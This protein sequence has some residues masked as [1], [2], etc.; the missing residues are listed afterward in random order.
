MNYRKSLQWY[1]RART[2]IPS[3]TQT[4]SKGPTQ[5]PFG[6]S[7][8]YIERGEGSHVWDVDGNEF[9]DYPMGLGA[10]LLGHAYPPVNA[11]IVEQAQK[12]FSFTL[13]SPLEVEVAESLTELIPCAEMVR[14]GKNGSDATAGAIRAARAFTGRDKVVC[15]GY[16]G[17]QDWYIATTT[18]DKGVPRFN[19]ELIYVFG[20]NDIES[21]KR[22]F[23]ENRN[24]IAAVIMEP[25]V[26]DEPLPGF[27]SQVR[28]VTSENGALLVF[29]EIVTGFRL[30]VGGAQ[31]YYNIRPDIACFG[32]G[33]GNGMPISA[34]AGRRE[35]MEVFDEVFFSFTFGGEA[36]SLAAAKATLREVVRTPVIEKIWR[37]G[38]ALK[39]GYNDV[40][41]SLGLEAIT[42]CTGLPP[43]TAISFH[44]T[45]EADGLELRTLFQQ[46]AIAR[47]ILAIGVHNVC[48][49]HTEKDVQRTLE[50]YEE[51]LAIM[52]KGIE[53]KDVRHRIKGKLVEPVFR[54]L[55]FGSQ[56]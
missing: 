17:W 27:L 41:K 1:D 4:F 2:I 24:E 10:V 48:Y 30:H 42:Q 37:L 40:V 8:I 15:C 50:A 19:K 47:G 21:L 45:P 33:L 18:R 11:A 6:V 38:K 34:V 36:L 49:S 25:V 56:V 3:A 5:Y 35:I 52:K 13:N 51:T 7:P 39:E 23:R 44:P 32:K 53:S 29:D 20:Y 55:K 9:I 14:F 31:A 43:R 12:G 54:P 16:H 22:I 28:E 46:E 26:L